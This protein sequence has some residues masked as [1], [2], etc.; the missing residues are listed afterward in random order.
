MTLK[1]NV[2][3]VEKLTVNFGFV[4]FGSSPCIFLK[5]FVRMSLEK[6]VMPVPPPGVGI[7][8]FMVRDFFP[9]TLLYVTQMNLSVNDLLCDLKIKEG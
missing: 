2:C 6:S 8:N 5:S 7:E 4:L 9:F 3:I 1:G